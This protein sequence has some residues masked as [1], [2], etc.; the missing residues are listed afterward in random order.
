MKKQVLIAGGGIGGLA[1]GIGATCAGCDVRLFERAR[2]FREVGAGI[3]LGPNVVRGLQA[4]GLQGSL[5]SVAAVPEALQARSALG[6]HALARLPLGSAAVQRYGAAYLTIHRADLHQLLLEALRRHA[7]VHLNLGQAME[8]LR[9]SDGVVTL[10][11][12]DGKLV[13]G[14]AL[15]CADG[16][17]SRLRTQLLGDGP[18]RPTGHLAYR[19]MV[20][21]ADLPQ[22][23]RTSEVTAWLGPRLHVVQYPVRRGELQNLVVIVQGPAPADMER[24]DHAANAADLESALAGTCSALQDLVHGVTDVGAE[25]RLWP[26]ADRPPLRSAGEMARGLVALLGDAAHPMRPYLAQG[27]GMAIEDAAELQR[28]L[29][30]HDLEMELRLRR[31]ALNRWQRNARVQARSRR[32]GRIFHATGPVRWGRDTALKLLGARIM[33]LPWLYQGDGS[34]ASSL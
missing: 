10:R 33:D 24:W 12:A 7:D 16:V 2:E 28:A 3:Q 4:W 18:P 30:M 8:S 26:L 13:E 21:Q 9:E 17:H 11:G 1:A 27:A 34:R 6:G 15:V 5:Q 25:W 14:D 29:S 22:Q 20:R 31:Y 19:A 23:L 32:N